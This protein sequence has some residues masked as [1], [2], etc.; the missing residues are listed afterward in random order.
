MSSPATDLQRTTQTGK[1]A[2]NATRSTVRRLHSVPLHAFVQLQ[3]CPAVDVQ[4]W[5]EPGL[6][7]AMR[8]GRPEAG[9]QQRCRGM[10]ALPPHAAALATGSSASGEAEMVVKGRGKLVP[11]PPDL[12]GTLAPLAAQCGLSG[13]EAELARAVAAH[14]EKRQQGIKDHGAA[15]A[16]YLAGLGIEQGVKQ[17]QLGRLLMRCPLLFSWPVEQRAGVLFGQLMA[18]GLTAAQ[19]ARCFEQQPSAALSRAFASAIAVLSPLMAAG[20]RTGDVGKTGEQLL[21][22]LLIGQPAASG[23]LQYDEQGLQQRIDNLL[24]L[25]LTEQQ[26]VAA[27]RRDWSLLKSPL[28]HLVA[29]EAVLQQELG[30]DRELWCKVLLRAPL[31]NRLSEDRLRQ[32]V[33]ALVAVSAHLNEQRSALLP[34]HTRCLPR[35]GVWQE[36]SAADGQRCTQVAHCPHKCVAARSSG[37]G[38]VRRGRPPGGSCQLRRGSLS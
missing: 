1:G 18:L 11:V 5:S 16:A 36:R 4:A 8:W 10:A 25:G 38:P 19:A 30:A 32:R 20:C 22:E 34:A 9:W 15:V 35:A 27:V 23:L 29:L 26:L 13:R 6:R 24:Q 14:V 12:A 2:F 37:V 7:Q 31:V 17:G 21:G 3:G 33:L 28:E